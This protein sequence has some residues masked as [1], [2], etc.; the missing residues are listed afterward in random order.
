MPLEPVPELS[1]LDLPGHT[2]TEVLELLGTRA[3]R[4]G[5]VRAGFAD[6]LVARERSAPTGLPTA[7]PVAIP[8]V[9]P[10]LVLRP[11]IGLVRLERPVAWGEMGA[12]DD[13]TV[14][15]AAV[16]LLLVDGAQADV[17]SQL[18]QVL[19]KED[20]YAELCDADGVAG[21]CT[22]FGTRLVAS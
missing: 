8:H 10:A 17:L 11:G 21:A 4:A 22:A 14:D 12:P 5:F 2:W 13:R 1:A 3:E 15:A 7:V 19:Q 9:D 20:W 6:A 18:M 16:L